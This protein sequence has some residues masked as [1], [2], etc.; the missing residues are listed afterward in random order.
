M[1]TPTSI[2]GAVAVRD[3][4]APASLIQRR[5]Q[6]FFSVLPSQV[7]DHVWLRLAE[8][9][10]N[11]T[12][13]LRSAAQR[14]P[15]ALMRALMDCARLG[16]EPGTDRFYLVPVGGR[17]EGWES[18]KGVIQRILN[19]GNYRKVVAEVVYE[20]ETFK[21]NPNRDE[22]PDHEIDWMARANGKPLMSYAYA[23]HHDGTATRVA[24]ADP[25]HIAKVRAAAKGASSPKSPWN[26]WP[27]D[28]YAKCAVKRLE[29]YVSTSNEDRRAKVSTIVERVEVGE[30][31]EA[32]ARD[33]PIVE[34]HTEDAE[35]Y[36]E[37]HDTE[38]NGDQE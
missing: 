17:I 28:M 2:T 7:V 31:S 36:D 3:E 13:E 15:G 9:A 8:S 35:F 29:A 11:K 12:P 32:P 38:T 24:V 22:L 30:L 21:F 10:V 19:S 25:G 5:K 4:T 20:G 6:D 33:E 34:E 27:D 16:H 18:Y 37:T 23:L 1:T 26:Q 14:D